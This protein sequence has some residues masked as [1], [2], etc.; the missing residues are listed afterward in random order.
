MRLFAGAM[1]PCRSPGGYRGGVVAGGTASMVR[2]RGRLGCRVTGSVRTVTARTGKG[3][4]VWRRSGR[5]SVR[6]GVQASARADGRVASRSVVVGG[7]LCQFVSL[8]STET[9]WSCLQECRRSHRISTHST[10]WRWCRAMPEIAQGSRRE[11][12]VSRA[13]SALG[14]ASRMRRIRALLPR[15]CIV[16]KSQPHVISRI[17]PPWLPLAF[18][19]G[20]R[21]C[22]YP[23]KAC[24]R[25][26]PSVIFSLLCCILLHRLS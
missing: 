3:R 12:N 22:L 26:Y 9:D 2:R 24:F 8:A 15:F 14:M 5:G 25:L 11:C 1:T 23:L 7:V 6:S 19:Y 16:V 21:V 20:L 17:A 4:S 13:T 18:H 10:H